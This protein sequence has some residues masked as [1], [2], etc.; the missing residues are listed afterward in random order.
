MFLLFTVPTVRILVDPLGIPVPGQGSG[1][2]YLVGSDL[3]LSC[4]VIPSP[5]IAIEFSW[6][7]STGCFADMQMTQNISVMSLNV[8]DSGVLY[9]L[10][11]I[12]GVEIFSQ[13]LELQVIGKEIMFINN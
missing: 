4:L 5:P 1:F 11:N 3:S 2:H 7:C 6:R 10:V 8:T 9:C 13:N 12:I